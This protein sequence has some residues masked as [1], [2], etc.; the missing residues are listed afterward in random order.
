MKKIFIIMALIVFVAGTVFTSCQ[1]SASKVDEAKDNLQ[2][3]TE[4]VI[5]ANQEL[6]QALKDSITQF[7]ISAKEK[8]KSNE[9][10][11]AALKVRIAKENAKTKIN[12]DKKLAA[13]EQKN[14]DMV[15]R[16][17]NYND[18]QQEKWDAFKVEYNHD[19]DELG[20]AFKDLTIKNVK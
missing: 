2:V 14:K 16:L 5:V 1:S 6:N 15:N 8:I 9:E 3:A 19:M 13:L 17:D 20:D 11:I 4:N 18:I 7:R 12:N 10:K